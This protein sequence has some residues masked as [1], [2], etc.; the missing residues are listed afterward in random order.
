MLMKDERE[1]IVLF[2]K[3]L[4]SN[5]L[6][7]GTGGNLS[8]YNREK[9]LIA[10]SPSGIDYFETKLEDIVIIN[11]D[12]ERI[13]G[14]K[15]PS[16]EVELHKIF[17]QNRTD[18]DAIIHTHSVYATTLSCLNW[19]LPAVHYLMALAGIDVRC[20]K[21]A[22]YGSKEIAEN[23]FE[24]MQDRNAVFLAN[25]GLLVGSNDLSNA[26][27][28]TEEIEFCSEVYYRSKCIGEP[29]ILSKDEMVKVMTKFKTYGQNS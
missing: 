8:I 2:G 14:T 16:S 11:I 27:S 22:T 15:K 13:E 25:H 3:N 1:Q 28:I 6:T 5:R 7:K 29:V 20:A 17:Y 4:V 10:I 12:G 18:I 26:F 19:S 9:Q 23:A 24:A 21:Y